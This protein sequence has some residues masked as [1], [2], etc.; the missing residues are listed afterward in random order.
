MNLVEMQGDPGIFH[1]AYL[2]LENQNMV[3]ILSFDSKAVKCILEDK[4]DPETI[5]EGF[6]LIYKNKKQI[7]VVNNNKK[8]VLQKTY[9]ALD[10]AKENNQIRAIQ[11]IIDF[12]IKYQDNYVSSFMLK[13]NV[14]DFFDMGIEMHHL[15]KS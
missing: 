11:I 2:E 15:M 10:I 13:N 4:L 5:K 7:T 3:S 6:P 9:S 14:L 8:I 12:I 1:N